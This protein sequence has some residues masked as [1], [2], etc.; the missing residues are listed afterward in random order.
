MEVLKFYNNGFDE[1]KEYKLYKVIRT[2]NIIQEFY[3]EII[4]EENLKNKIEDLE[5]QLMISQ[6]ALDALI[7]SQI[8]G[9]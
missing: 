5:T 1:T 7:L 9:G 6:E 8:E 3:K 2:E 4:K